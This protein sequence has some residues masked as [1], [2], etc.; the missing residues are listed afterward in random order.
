MWKNVNKKIDSKKNMELRE[1]VGVNFNTQIHTHKENMNHRLS[2]FMVYIYFLCWYYYKTCTM[3]PSSCM[4][5]L[6]LLW[7]FF[8]FG[9]Y[10]LGCNQLSVCTVCEYLIIYICVLIIELIRMIRMLMSF[11]VS[12]IIWLGWNGM[13]SG[14]LRSFGFESR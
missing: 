7:T 12:T 9:F 6:F 11:N 13:E 2:F 3:K 8:W 1:V 5:C 14:V 4:M 10:Y